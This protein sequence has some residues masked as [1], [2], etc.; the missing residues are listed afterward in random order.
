MSR[1]QEDLYFAFPGQAWHLASSSS[2]R[3]GAGAGKMLEAEPDDDAVSNSFLTPGAEFRD[4]ESRSLHA[5]ITSMD[6][7][8]RGDSVARNAAPAG[9]G[10]FVRVP[11]NGRDILAGKFDRRGPLWQRDEDARVCT[12]CSKRFTFVRRRHHCRGCGAIFCFKC[13]KERFLLPWG[14]N[15]PRRCCLLCTLQVKGI[16]D[17]ILPA[18]LEEAKPSTAAS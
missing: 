3:G 9:P 14:G 16:Q 11:V 17:R 18:V 13:T 2:I 5:A 15:K 1:F 10:A 4:N 7:D 6:Y 8:D 12:D